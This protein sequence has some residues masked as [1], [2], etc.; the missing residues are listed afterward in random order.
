MPNIVALILAA[1]Q[2][3]RFGSP[4]QL[5]KWKESNLLANTIKTVCSSNASNVFLV[6]GA[7]YDQ[8]LEKT[9]TDSVE[10][11]K[12]KYWEQ[13]LGN[14]IAF[15]VNHIIKSNINV[16]GILLTLADQPLVDSDY[17]NSIISMFES[18]NNQII[19]SSY[20]NGKK[21]VPALFDPCYFDEL[22]KLKGDKGAKEIMEKHSK[23]VSVIE[24]KHKLTDIDTFQDYEK[25]YKANHQ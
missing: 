20:S 25:L 14:S 19:A 8:I 23:N 24:G 10:V 15:G 21:G 11:I 5:L 22:I 18:G 16:D 9:D 6:L 2:S 4:K 12:N 3:K 1:G 17:L 13:G 7:M